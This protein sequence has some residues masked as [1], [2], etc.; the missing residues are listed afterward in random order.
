MDA[1][2]ANEDPQQPRNQLGFE[3]GIQVADSARRS[4]PDSTAK[5]NHCLG[6][7]GG[8]AIV[9]IVRSVSRRHSALDAYDGLIRNFFA[10]MSAKHM[11]LVARSK[12]AQPAIFQRRGGLF[13]AY[14]RQWYLSSMNCKHLYNLS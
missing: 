14:P 10:A 13:C 5:A 4:E 1:Q 7:C 8:T 6:H 2:P 9:T 11:P 12:K 3:C